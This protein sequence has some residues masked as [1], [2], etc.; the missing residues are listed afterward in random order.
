M[1]TATSEQEYTSFM[2]KNEE[3]VVVPKKEFQRL[4]SQ[5]K[6]PKLY[7]EVDEEGTWETIDF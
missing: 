3:F 5:D 2:V 4:T 7:T 6:Y 1:A